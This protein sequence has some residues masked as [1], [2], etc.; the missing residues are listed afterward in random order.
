MKGIPV[1]IIAK[2]HNGTATL[3]RGFVTIKRSGFLARATVG[4]GDKRIP[5]RHITG[6]QIKPAGR[7]VNGFI[8]FTVP[9][10]NERR[11]AFGS[12]T[13]TAASDEN[14]VVFTRSQQAAFEALRDAIEQAMV[15]A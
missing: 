6:V 14:S 3:D 2:G 5:V 10:G 15:A 11:S 1:V 12:Q 9:G 8:Q 7:L 4:K 13:H